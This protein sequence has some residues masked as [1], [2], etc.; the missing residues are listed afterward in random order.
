MGLVILLGFGGRIS[1]VKN[2]IFFLFDLALYPYLRCFIVL[3][4]V[5]HP[6]PFLRLDTRFCKQGEVVQTCMDLDGLQRGIHPV[7]FGFGVERINGAG[8]INQD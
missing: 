3:H 2:K 8:L 6:L 7:C 5:F 1:G 4:L